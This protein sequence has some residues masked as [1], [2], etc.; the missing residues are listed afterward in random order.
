VERFKKVDDIAVAFI[1]F[2]HKSNPS[3]LSLFGTILRQIFESQSS[4]SS[5]IRKIYAAHILRGTHP[6]LE[7][8]STLLRSE[9]ERYSTV[10]VVIDALDEC[11]NRDDARLLLLTELRKLQ[12]KLRLLVTSRSYI[13]DM[14]RLFPNTGRLEI[15]AAEE[16]IKQYL[17]VKISRER[18]LNDHVEADPRLKDDIIAAIVENVKGM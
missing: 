14:H 11:S 15:W 6:S 13:S 1:Y 16:D 12:P 8:Y 2:N 18:R 7:D 10:Y 17:A 5:A 9:V 4:V 3:K